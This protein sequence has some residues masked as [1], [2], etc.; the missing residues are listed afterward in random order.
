MHVWHVGQLGCKLGWPADDIFHFRKPT[1]LLALNAIKRVFKPQRPSTKIAMRMEYTVWLLLREI[2][3][4]Y[5]ELET[6]DA[7]F[8]CEWINRQGNFSA[9]PR[10]EARESEQCAARRCLT[11]Q[12]QCSEATLEPSLKQQT[13]LASLRRIQGTCRSALCCL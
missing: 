5:L 3:C 1:I 7:L 8:T 6:G 4:A 11:K 12:G 9:A 10:K 13:P 2:S